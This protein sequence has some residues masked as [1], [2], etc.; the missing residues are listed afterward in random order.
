MSVLQ[1]LSARDGWTEIEP[2][3][4]DIDGNVIGVHDGDVVRVGFERTDTPDTYDGDDYS[5]Y[6]SGPYT[7]EVRD[8]P[9]GTRY[10]RV[11]KR[12][13]TD[14]VHTTRA[15]ETSD[16]YYELTLPTPLVRHL[17][18]DEVVDTDTRTVTTTDGAVTQDVQR[19]VYVAI[20]T[21]WV[22]AGVRVRLRR[23]HPDE[24]WKSTVRRIQRKP[25]TGGYEQFF[26]YFP[27]S[28]AV[29][30]D[31]HDA[32]FEWRVDT[33]GQLVAT[34]QTVERGGAEL[35]YTDDI[36]ATDLA[37]APLAALPYHYTTDP[38]STTT[39]SSMRVGD[40]NIGIER[41]DRSYA[42]TASDERILPI[43]AREQTKQT[44]LL[45]R[46]AHSRA[47]RLIPDRKPAIIQQE[48]NVTYLVEWLSDGGYAVVIHT[49]PEALPVH[50]RSDRNTVSVSI[51]NWFDSD[52]ADPDS[53]SLAQKFDRAGNQIS[54]NFPK[55]IALT[56]DFVDEDLYWWPVW[57]DEYYGTEALMLVGRPVTDIDLEAF[58]PDVNHLTDVVRI[59]E[60]AGMTAD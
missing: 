19:G 29:A 57:D 32:V 59:D 21:E 25:V 51:N 48:L 16:G 37:D 50:R 1:N 13:V 38:E 4:D 52:A 2:A 12:D 9:E 6:Q 36:A 28:V 34:I 60:T 42:D 14:R 46:N 3:P 45:L 53:E 15:V 5:V 23:A 30:L 40:R 41:R 54:L 49:A 39:V 20:E 8:P 44:R 31:I 58:D 55:D 7:V 47:L 26:I 43:T 17:D 10:V 27:R 56:F 11:A 33:T 35:S 18:L 24:T 22:D